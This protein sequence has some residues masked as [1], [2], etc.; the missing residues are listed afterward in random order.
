MV[1][2]DT[3]VLAYYLLRTEGVVEEARTFWRVAQDVAAPDSWR[4][5]LANV[6]WLAIRAGVIDLRGAQR[7]FRRAESLIGKTVS[8]RSL[9]PLALRLA[10]QSDHPAYD[11]LFVA[12][13][14]REGGPL[15]TF[16]RRV[17]ERFP[18]IARRPSDL[19]TP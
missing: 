19:G 10:V 15:A 17:L 8:T 16:D 11:T 6:L 9:R 4:A 3:N 14:I 12:L 2:A 5:E 7:R 18:R 1:V 13:A